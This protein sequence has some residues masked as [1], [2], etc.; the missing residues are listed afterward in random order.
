ML[1]LTQTLIV[2]SLMALGSIVTIT[3]RDGRKRKVMTFISTEFPPPYN[4]L[5][6]SCQ[7]ISSRFQRSHD[8]GRLKRIVAGKLK[9]QFVICSVT[10]TRTPCDSSNLLFTLKRGTTAKEAQAIAEKLFNGRDI[11]T[12]KGGVV[13]GDETVYNAQDYLDNLPSE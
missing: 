11:A 9:G 2:A 8:N 6:N 1:K 3:T 10:S 4:N 5:E 7:L 12:S 13:R